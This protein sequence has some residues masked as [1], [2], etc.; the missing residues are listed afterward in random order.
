M[1]REQKLHFGVIL[2]I[3]DQIQ[4]FK[5]LYYANYYTE[6]EFF[7]HFLQKQIFFKVLVIFFR[8]KNRF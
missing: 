3:F 4:E 8:F 7:N 1:D 2:P 6:S 5:T